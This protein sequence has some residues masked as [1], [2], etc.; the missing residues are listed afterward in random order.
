MM[1]P[2]LEY[3]NN[4]AHKWMCCFGVP[5]A[6]H[7]WQVADASSLNGSYKIEVAKAKRKYLEYRAVPKFEPTD[8][9]PL[10]NMAFPKSFGRQQNAVKA[11]TS[12][13][14]NPLNYNILTT[15]PAKE[16]DL[17]VDDEEQNTI[18][19]A[20]TATTFPKINIH[21]GSASFYLDKLIGEERKDEGRK[22]KFETIKS[23]Q[24]T[25]QQKIE[26]LK[27]LTKVSSAALAANNHYTLDE[28]ILQI[29]LDKEAADEAAKAATQ[30]RKDAA[31]IKRADMLKKALQKFTLCPN[32]LTVPDL[33]ILV[34]AA[35]RE[36]DSPIRKKK[37]ELQE[38]LYREPRY[39]RVQAMA[40][41]LQLTSDAA[42]AAAEALLLVSLPP[43]PVATA[44]P[45][46]V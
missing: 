29:I 5:Y 12:Q 2:F 44:D 39:A 20:A 16:I 32:G 10:V 41:E 26:H 37:N 7:V 8:I 21:A 42:A 23:Q 1:R 35:T 25:K 46:A 30:A 11:I 36:P 33:K 31:E 3:V 4:P 38:Q 9:V 15:L 19:A 43:P 24:Q 14:W 34:G 45:T 6:T 17:T 28:N 22:R 18:T 40:S 27:S 13:G